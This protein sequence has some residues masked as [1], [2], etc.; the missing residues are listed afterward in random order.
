MLFCLTAEY[1]TAGDSEHLP[2]APASPAG[3][4]LA[5]VEETWLQGHRVSRNGRGLSSF[6][7]CAAV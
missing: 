1:S 7:V 4:F 2:L 5:R 3:F 6:R